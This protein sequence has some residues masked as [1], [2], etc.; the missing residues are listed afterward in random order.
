MTRFLLS[1]AGLVLALPSALLWLGGVFHFG[2]VLALVLGLVLWVVA[3]F[4]SGL[5]CWVDAQ[6][7]R[8]RLWRLSVGGMSVWALSVLAFFAIPVPT[9]NAAALSEDPKALIVL[10]G[11]S[12]LCVPSPV[13]QLRLDTAYAAALR[14]PSA[15]VVLSG[16]RNGFHNVSCSEA[17]VM[18][19]ALL[20]KGLDASRV[21]EEDASTSTEENL[22]FSAQLLRARGLGVDQPLA[23]VT[24]DYHGFRA[25]RNG[26][27]LGMSRLR[28]VPAATPIRFRYHLWLREYFAFCWSWVK[29][30]V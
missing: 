27:R 18:Q 8:R 10:G 5:F 19:K 25:M 15:L 14:W 21:L 1:V 2:V 6:P 24:S 22:A 7:W 11:G 23:V 9:G 17:E 29:G 26:A 30:E 12:A 16:G 20:A 13:V 28:F 3:A 4:W